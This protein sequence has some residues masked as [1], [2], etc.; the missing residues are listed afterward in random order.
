MD[1]QELN[2]AAAAQ[3]GGTSY[4]AAP[5]PDGDSDGG[6]EDG[7]NGP[8][9]KMEIDPAEEGGYV[10]THHKKVPDRVKAMD[11]DKYKPR[12]HVKKNHEELVK[13]VE[14]HGKR[15]QP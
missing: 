8:L 12:T 15:V 11:P 4:T 6:M 13:H 7:D 3:Q 2:Q 5:Q 9:S 14:K 1:E 10:V